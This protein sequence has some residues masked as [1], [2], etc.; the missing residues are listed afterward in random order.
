MANI[1]RMT[2]KKLGEILVQA[3]VV[4]DLQLQ[5]ALAEQAGSGGLLGEILVRR[6]M[7]NETDIVRT[8]ATQFSLPYLSAEQL[9]ISSKVAKLL[10]VEFMRRNHL[11]PL[12]RFGN[13]LTVLIAGMLGADVLTQIEKQTDCKV[14]LFIGTASDVRELIAQIDAVAAENKDKPD[15]SEKPA[16]APP[17]ASPKQPVGE[18]SPAES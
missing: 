8:I 1:Q 14:R 16:P 7:V 11:V 4:D 18:R 15:K 2:R 3:G 13:C 9:E 6:G 12:D 17:A 10:P 5:A